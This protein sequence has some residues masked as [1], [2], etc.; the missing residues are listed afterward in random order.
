MELSSSRTGR[1]RHFMLDGYGTVVM[2]APFR[3]GFAPGQ[4]RWYALYRV[5]TSISRLAG[6]LTVA[7]GAR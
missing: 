2:L 3:L 7:E 4:R 6:E 1:P 5:Q